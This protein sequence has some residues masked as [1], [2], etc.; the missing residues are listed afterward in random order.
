MLEDK[1]HRPSWREMPDAMRPCC[2]LH[3]TA[4]W[5]ARLLNTCSSAIIKAQAGS[6]R[7][8][9]LDV[10]PVAVIRSIGDYHADISEQTARVRLKRFDCRLDDT[11]RYV[12]CVRQHEAE[13]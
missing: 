12:V 13:I 3:D 8:M 9:Y 7:D 11:G 2:Q 5:Y 10:C 1:L 6:V 4:P